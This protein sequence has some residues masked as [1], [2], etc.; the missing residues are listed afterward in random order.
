MKLQYKAALITTGIVS[1]V[2]V[3]ASLLVFFPEV[4]AALILG[5][6]FSSMTWHIYSDILRRL[7]R[8]AQKTV[9]PK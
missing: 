6:L 8:A 2:A 1:A 9:D 7:E 3:T 4:F 5:A